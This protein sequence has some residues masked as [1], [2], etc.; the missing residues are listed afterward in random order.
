[1]R[2][3]EHSHF[4]IAHRNL[5]LPVVLLPLFVTSIYIYIYWEEIVLRCRRQFP[6]SVCCS[7]STS[8]RRRKKEN[9]VYFFPVSLFFFLCL[10]N[11]KIIRSNN[12]GY[13][14]SILYVHRLFMLIAPTWRLKSLIFSLF[15]FSTNEH[16]RE[17][18]T[19]SE[20]MSV[21]FAF[22]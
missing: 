1:M 19:E 14:N 17:R 7:P 3:L 10:L 13:Y 15:L 16:E 8:W 22:F 2:L 11:S 20:R 9:H 5:I 18:Q 4:I 21:S 12:D 6:F